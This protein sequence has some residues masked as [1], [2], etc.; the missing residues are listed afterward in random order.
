MDKGGS[1]DDGKEKECNMKD[2]KRKGKMEGVKKK[3]GC[4]WRSCT[5]I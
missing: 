1:K 2:R 5:I 4:R 3:G